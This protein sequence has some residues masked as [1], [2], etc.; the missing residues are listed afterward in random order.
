MHGAVQANELIKEW[1]PLHTTKDG[2]VWL[3]RSGVTKLERYAEDGLEDAKTLAE[4]SEFRKKI[5]L[6]M[7]KEGIN[8]ANDIFVETNIPSKSSITRLLQILIEK[9]LIKLFKEEKTRK[10]GKP[11]K[12]F[13]LTK[14]GEAYLAG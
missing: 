6:R 10:G 8:C 4:M 3:H 11:K 7:I 14:L 5:V 9:K 12:R 13:K 1:R 2:V